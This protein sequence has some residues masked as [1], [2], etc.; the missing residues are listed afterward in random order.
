MGKKHNE[1]REGITRLSFVGAAKRRGKPTK[2]TKLER[3]FETDHQG[4]ECS[5][6]FWTSHD[7]GEK[8]G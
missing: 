7:G 6:S 5:I 4:N 8:T 1:Q 2:S 3:V